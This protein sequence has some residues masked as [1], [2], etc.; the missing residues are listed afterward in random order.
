MHRAIRIVVVVSLL[1]SAASFLAWPVSFIR[2]AVISRV[3][4]DRSDSFR[5]F[6]GQ[7]VWVADAGPAMSVWLRGKGFVPGQWLGGTNA[8]PKAYFW[9]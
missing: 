3:G 8:F 6:G 4:A 7:L 5:L 2:S 1:V 9:P